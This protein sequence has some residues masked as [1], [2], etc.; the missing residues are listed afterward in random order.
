M[1]L[2]G[3]PH[4]AVVLARVS[5]SVWVEAHVI[6]ETAR[7]Q[8]R[9]NCMTEIIVVLLDKADEFDLATN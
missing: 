1:R 4:N 8:C 6:Y 7:G 3:V 5:A 2:T 9:Y